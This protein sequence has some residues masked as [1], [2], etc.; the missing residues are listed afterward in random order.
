LGAFASP[1]AAMPAADPVFAALAAYAQADAEWEVAQERE[2][3][4][5]AADHEMSRRPRVKIGMWAD[6]VRESPH[7]NEERPFYLYDEEAIQRHTAGPSSKLRDRLLAEFR[8]EAAR[9]EERQRETGYTEAVRLCKE[10]F[11]RRCDCESA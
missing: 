1:L 4:I 5:F 7:Y 6:L 8:A 9:Q 2:D 10:A 11:Q 3:T